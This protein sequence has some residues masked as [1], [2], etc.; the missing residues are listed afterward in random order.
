MKYAVNIR[1]EVDSSEYDNVDNEHDVKCLVQEM[2]NGRADW[3]GNEEIEV[4]QLS[5]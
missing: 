2:I 4:T 1:L 5:S 3:E